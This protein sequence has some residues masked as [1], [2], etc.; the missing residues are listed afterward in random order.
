MVPGRIEFLG[1]HTDYAGGRSLVGA[2]ERAIHLV[3]APRADARLRVVDAAAGETAELELRPDLEARPGHWTNYVTTVAR[4]LARN[5]PGSPALRGADLAFASD[6]PPAAGISSSSALIIALF[7]AL[8]DVNALDRRPAYSSQI[9][10]V[11]DLAGYLGAIENG[12][13]FGAFTGD[14]G[15]GT[16]G[17]SQD[18]TAILCGRS[19][20]LRQFSF[21]PVR[22]ERDVPFP[23]DWTLVI[24][25]SGVVADKTGGA[26][27]HYN[28]AARAVATMLAA[29]RAAT[30]RDDPSLAAALASAPDAPDRLRGLVDP[31]LLPRLDQFIAESEEIVPAAGDALLRGDVTALGPLVGRSQRLAEENLGNQVP[32]TIALA[33]AARAQGAAAASAFGAGFGGSV[34]A[35]VETRAAAA[36]LDAWRDAYRREFPAAAGRAEFFPTGVGEGMRR[37]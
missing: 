23:A 22:H 9:H 1:K 32:E 16:L 15:V 24:A 21:C 20:F 30:G 19:G 25:V 36:F 7:T 28:R 26:R 12:A 31:S 11:E 34:W 37:V 10:S 27:E 13:T 4:R 2:V 8:A 18:H 3:A 29:W 14:A 5:F 17:G 35:L 6:L 33:R